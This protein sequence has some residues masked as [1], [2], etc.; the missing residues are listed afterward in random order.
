M[1]NPL[2]RGNEGARP[3]L[4]G[5]DPDTD[6]RYET[7]DVALI[8]PGAALRDRSPDSRAGIVP[9]GSFFSLNGKNSR[10]GLLSMQ[11]V[12][13]IGENL[14]PAGKQQVSLTMA[15]GTLQVPIVITR[16][17][18]AMRTKKRN[19]RHEQRR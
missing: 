3:I 2:C 15:N 13:A 7:A 12:F 10:P 17:Q 18:G 8:A 6:R 9:G 16:T 1:I 14:R 5:N 11:P 4:N 19:M